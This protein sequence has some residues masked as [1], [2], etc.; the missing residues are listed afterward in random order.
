[1]NGIRLVLYVQARKEEADATT[2]SSVAWGD[3]LDDAFPICASLVDSNRNEMIALGACGFL[4]VVD[5]LNS[6]TL[7][8]CQEIGNKFVGN[9]LSV[10]DLAFKISR[11]GPVVVAI[12]QTQSRIFAML[13]ELGGNWESRY[14]NRRRKVTRQ[15]LTT[16]ARSSHQGA[17]DSRCWNLLVGGLISLLLQHAK[18]DSKA[19]IMELGRLGLSALLPL[20]DADI[21]MDQKTLVTSMT[22]M[23]NLLFGAYPIMPHHGGK[24]LCHL[25][26]AASLAVPTSST[27][28][29]SIYTSATALVICGPKFTKEIIDSILNGQDS[30]QDIMVATTSEVTKLAEKL[31]E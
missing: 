31:R 26:S 11:E 30:F 29:L 2:L 8:D 5:S 9:T 16:L 23:I 13:Q 25:L 21:V 17:S 20:T 28:K 15:W 6:A 7:N 24:I 27:R 19:D 10:L 18:N 12:G 3:V 22:A 14:R 4:R 1:M